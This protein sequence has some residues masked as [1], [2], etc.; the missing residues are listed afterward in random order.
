M[1]SLLFVVNLHYVFVPNGPSSNVESERERER[2][3]ERERE[4]VCVCVCVFLRKLL[5]CFSV[6]IA[7]GSFL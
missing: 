4:N 5:F 2:G 6:E 3:R 1:F 7:S